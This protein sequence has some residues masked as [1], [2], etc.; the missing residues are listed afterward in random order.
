MNDIHKKQTICHP[1]K[2][3][4]VVCKGAL[5]FKI[6]ATADSKFNVSAKD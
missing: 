3:D 5:Q 2:G 1:P 6:S 4:L